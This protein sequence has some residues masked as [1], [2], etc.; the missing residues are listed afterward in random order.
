[1]SVS[2][3]GVQ[4]LQLMV[5]QGG[6][7][8]LTVAEGQELVTAKCIE[9][10]NPLQTSPVNASAFLCTIT[11]YGKS[12][13]PQANPIHQVSQVAHLTES[14]TAL[15]GNSTITIATGIPVPT[16]K[17]GA[18][19]GAGRKASDPKYPF[20]VLEIGQSFHVPFGSED[21][22]KVSRV[23]STAVS[24]ANSDSKV[25]VP[26]GEKEVVIRKRAKKDAEGNVLK[27]EEGT[28]LF[29]T[30]QEESVKMQQT[31]FFVSRKVGADDPQGPGIRVF[32]V[33]EHM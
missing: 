17:R 18:G 14:N 29:E 13:I 30:Y 11:E 15:V 28:R 25:P 7:A 16:I 5:S 24:N 1:M 27:N 3:N 4:A 31:K 32:R 26:T 8:Y 10:V 12:I 19:F 6:Q 22:A 33:A 2:T 21:V 20:A 9:V 23:V